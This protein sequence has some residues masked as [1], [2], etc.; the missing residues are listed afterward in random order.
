MQRYTVRDKVYEALSLSFTPK[1]VTLVKGD[2]GSVGEFLH[3][4]HYN[5]VDEDLIVSDAIAAIHRSLAEADHLWV[6][7]YVVDDDCKFVQLC[8]N[9][10]PK[11]FTATVADRI[12]ASLKALPGVTYS[13][14]FESLDGAKRYGLCMQMDYKPMESSKRVIDEIVKHV[15][16]YTTRGH[17]V[18]LSYVEITI[19]EGGELVINFWMKGHEMHSF[20]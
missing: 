9:A 15:N 17:K 11:G 6:G 2:L 7:V 18:D 13:D 16:Y 1:Q 19:V 10:I 3:D 20:I 12:K 5:A 8:L 4:L 14:S